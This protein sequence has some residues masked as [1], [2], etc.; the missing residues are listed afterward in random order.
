MR[1]APRQDLARVARRACC[2]RLQPAAASRRSASA[3]SRS[4]RRADSFAR[5]VR[6]ADGPSCCSRLT[7][8]STRSVICLM[9]SGRGAEA[10]LRCGRRRAAAATA[11][12]RPT[13]CR[14]G[15]ALRAACRAARSRA[16]RRRARR[17]SCSFGSSGGSAKKLMH[18]L[19]PRL[20]A[21][22]DRRAL[23]RRREVIADILEAGRALPGRRQR[24]RR[25]APAAAAPRRP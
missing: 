22:L 6:S 23:D 14:S 3:R 13:R 25:T 9:F 1:C 17:C 8:W 4:A 5:F 24:R 15:R 21:L 16:R 2:D 10:D 12:G 20:P 18:R 11:T 19:A 7:S